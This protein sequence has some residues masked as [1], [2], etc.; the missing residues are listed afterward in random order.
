VAERF[1]WTSADGKVIELTD[2]VAGLSV[3]ANGTRG[4]RSVT[5]Q[6]TTERFAGMDG[7]TV[8][9]ITAEPT[10][11]SLGLLLRA[12]DEAE[13]RQRMRMLVRAMRPKAGMGTLS[14]GTE[15]GETRNLGC[16]LEGG[17]EGD[18]SDD[19]H[20]P[21][22]WW[23]AVLRFYAPDPWWL[24]SERIV[25]FGLG[26]PIPFYPIPPVAL[27]SSTVQGQFTLD[28]SDMDEP[29]FPVWTVTGPGSMLVLT[30]RTSGR[31]L[32]VNVDLA[33]GDTLTVDTRPNL[34]SIRLG[35]GTNAMP[36]VLGYPDLWPLIDTVNDLQVSLTGATAATQI[37]G[38]YRPRYAGI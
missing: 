3:Q 34:E 9:A 36:A 31:S 19:T 13:L 27:S 11:P 7:E 16:Y 8:R 32:T 18:Q 2:P 33:A 14:V 21:G 30:N 6:F 12:R 5:Y 15:T 4:L 10:R 35:N 1:V 38:S 22:M 37:V 26:A 23:R 20:M 29:T 25:K 17:L 24:G 28:L